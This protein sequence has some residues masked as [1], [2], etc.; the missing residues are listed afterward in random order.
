MDK[1][2]RTIQ[3]PIDEEL[4]ERIDESAAILDENR[5]TFIREACQQRVKRLQDK[6]LAK[7]ISA[8]TRRSPKTQ[9]G[10]KAPLNCSLPA[11]PK[12]SGRCSEAKFGGSI[13]RRP[14]VDGRRYF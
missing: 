7:F 11:S 13:Y 2:K 6:K 10:V 12:K 9:N 3:I 14:R 8:A 4:L 1:A 5:A